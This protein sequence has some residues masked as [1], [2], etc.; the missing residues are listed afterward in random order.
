MH[1]WKP[2]ICILLLLGVRNLDQMQ[3]VFDQIRASGVKTG[4]LQMIHL[5]LTSFAS[6]RLFVDQVHKINQPVRALINNG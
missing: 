2:Q 4:S 3:K 1:N 6:I 5:D